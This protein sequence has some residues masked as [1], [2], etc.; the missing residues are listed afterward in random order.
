MIFSRRTA[1]QTLGLTDPVTREEIG[2]AWKRAVR[3]AHPDAGGAGDVAELGRARDKLLSDADIYD[4]AL[5][6]CGKNT[7]CKMC[8]GQGTVRG[9]FGAIPCTSCN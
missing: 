6:N 2:A 1:L 3:A 9:R 7:S 5:A 4:R 8:G